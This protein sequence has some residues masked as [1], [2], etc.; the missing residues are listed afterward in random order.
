MREIVDIIAANW[1]SVEIG[2]KASD[3]YESRFLALDSTKANQELKWA[4]PWAIGETVARS[5]AWYQHYY[6]D[7]ASIARQTIAQINDYRAGLSH[8]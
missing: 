5:V 4:S 3:L 7:P 6:S 8:N 2:H 1:R